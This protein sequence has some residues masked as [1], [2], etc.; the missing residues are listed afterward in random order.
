MIKKD[1]IHKIIIKINNVQFK[2]Q[3]QKFFKKS[4]SNKILK[5]FLVKSDQKKNYEFFQQINYFFC[6]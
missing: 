1:K 5:K 4:I 2:N 3:Y 6:K